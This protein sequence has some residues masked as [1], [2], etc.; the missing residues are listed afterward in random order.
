MKIVT[1]ATEVDGLRVVQDYEEIAKALE[2]G[3]AVLHW[4]AG[5]SLKPLINHLEYCAISPIDPNDVKVG[6]CV[7]CK[8]TDAESKTKYY[9][10]HQVWQISDG[11][12]DGRKWFKIGSSM[13]T[14]YG[15]TQE[16]LGLAKGTDIYQDPSVWAKI[17]EEIEFN[18]EKEV[19][20]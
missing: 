9:M 17:M 19:Y 2:N 18:Q 8:M 3:E 12:H 14:V 6:D 4:E 15:W 10:V 7:F 11:G 16:V 20:S 1:N 13:T 5:E